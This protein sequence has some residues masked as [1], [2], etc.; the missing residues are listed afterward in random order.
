MPV[1][2]DADGD[3]VADKDQLF[4]GGGLTEE[5]KARYIKEG[6]KFDTGGDDQHSVNADGSGNRS[7]ASTKGTDKVKDKDKDKGKDKDKSKDKVKDKD[8]DKD[9][10]KARR[11]SVA[12]KSSEA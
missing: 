2:E 7:V 12:A 9:K 5:A 10:D 4:P 6:R 8:K 11:S 3:G 1:E